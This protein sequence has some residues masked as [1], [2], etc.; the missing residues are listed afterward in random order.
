MEHVDAALP[1]DGSVDSGSAVATCVSVSGGGCGVSRWKSRPLQ[2][3]EH[4]DAALPTDGSVDNESL[5]PR[6]S[7]SVEVA[8]VAVDGSRE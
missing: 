1:T 5:P 4:V 8:A 7:V 3:V 2:L 6:V